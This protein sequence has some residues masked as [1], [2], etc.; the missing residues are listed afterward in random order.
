MREWL[1]SSY[2]EI[3]LSPAQ[4]QVEEIK[5]QRRELGLPVGEKD[6]YGDDPPR[7]PR[8]DPRSMDF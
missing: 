8:R 6:P 7:P 4:R 1:N 3:E 5:R 2:L